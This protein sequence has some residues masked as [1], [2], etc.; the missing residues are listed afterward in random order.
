MT[1]HA[2]SLASVGE[3][4]DSDDCTTLILESF[5]SVLQ[6]ESSA[7]RQAGMGLWITLCVIAS[8]HRTDWIGIELMQRCLGAL[9]LQE[10]TR[11]DA[12]RLWSIITLRS[13]SGNGKPFAHSTMFY[14]RRYIRN[15][16]TGSSIL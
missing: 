9:L 1:S 2:L 4:R 13:G 3:N 16:S 8:T 15:T 5:L 7:I 14:L 10:T 11:K 6:S 12:V